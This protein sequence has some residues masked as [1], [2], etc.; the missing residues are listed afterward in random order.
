MELRD[1]LILIYEHSWV[2]IIQP[3]RTFETCRMD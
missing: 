3:D 2:A 1:E